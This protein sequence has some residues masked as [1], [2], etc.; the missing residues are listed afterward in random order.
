ML[1]EGIGVRKL[2]SVAE[3]SSISG[4][5]QQTIR[6]MMS[7]DRWPIRRFNIGRRVLT[8]ADEFMEA[9]FSGRLGRAVKRQGRPR[10]LF[11]NDGPGDGPGSSASSPN[12][13]GRREPET[14]AE[15]EDG[16]PDGDK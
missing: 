6:N 9:I 15:H 4:I 13:G 11:E 1:L 2:L 16:L 3:M 5:A 8:P 7:S 12:D 10:K 14:A